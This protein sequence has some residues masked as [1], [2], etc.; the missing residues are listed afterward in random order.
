MFEECFVFAGFIYSIYSIFSL[1]N[2][3]ICVKIAF[4][5]FY[6]A[7]ACSSQLARDVEAMLFIV[8]PPSSTLAQH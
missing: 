2:C 8:R 6:Q 4:W 5:A 7:K 1:Q 3:F